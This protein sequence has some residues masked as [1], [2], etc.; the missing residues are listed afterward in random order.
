MK[1]LDLIDLNGVGPAILRRMNVAGI[2]SIA[3]LASATDEQ[4]ASIRGLEGSRGRTLRTRARMV[5]G[6]LDEGALDEGALGEGALGE[7]VTGPTESD[8]MIDDLPKYEVYPVEGTPSGLSYSPCVLMFEAGSSRENVEAVEIA[9]ARWNNSS[10]WPNLFAVTI[11]PHLADVIVGWGSQ[12][13]Q[14]IGGSP[15]RILLPRHGVGVTEISRIL[16]VILGVNAAPGVRS[17]MNGAQRATAK[18]YEDAAL[19]LSQADR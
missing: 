17:I 13:I 4:L 3:A 15:A 19:A 18:D 11:D 16:G 14:V 7:G 10:T 1:K 12:G 8:G 6:A 9:V 2:D 5:E